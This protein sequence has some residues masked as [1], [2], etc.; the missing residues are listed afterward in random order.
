MQ[1]PVL[2][3]NNKVLLPLSSVRKKLLRE[4]IL[5]VQLISTGVV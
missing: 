3:K 1:E 2:A 4:Q 5:E